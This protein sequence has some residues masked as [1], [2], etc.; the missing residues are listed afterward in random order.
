MLP[1]LEWTAREI[2]LW[3]DDQPTASWWQDSGASTLRGYRVMQVPARMIKATERKVQNDQEGALA[4]LMPLTESD[5]WLPD[6]TSLWHWQPEL[7]HALIVANRIDEAADLA[8]DFATVTAKAPRFVRATALASRARVAAARKEIDQAEQLYQESITVDTHKTGWQPTTGAIWYAYGQ[9][10]RRAGRRRDAASRL[11]SARDFFE[12][13]DVTVM[14][15]RCN[16]ELRAT[17]M[18]QHRGEETESE[19]VDWGGSEQA[20]VHLTP[21]EH[22]IAQ[23]VVQGLTNRETASR[24]FIAEK[25]V[26]YHLTRIYAKFTIR[27]RTELARVYQGAEESAGAEHP[28]ADPYRKLRDSSLPSIC[29]RRRYATRCA[30]A[31]EVC[32]TRSVV[33]TPEIVS[34]A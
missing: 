31:T 13:V 6:H 14:V 30:G 12:S 27:S 4:A 24:L 2:Q 29:V 8:E 25:T 34:N 18:V 9:M 21:Q 28:P 22:A 11:V 26:Q 33:E 7:I 15:E 32:S 3:R 16:Q 19:P 23:L 17:G 1:L 5:P 20:S 10:L